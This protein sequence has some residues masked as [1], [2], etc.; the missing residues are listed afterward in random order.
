M[1]ISLYLL[2]KIVEYKVPKEV[3]GS[4][5]FPADEEDVNIINFEARNGMWVLYKTTDVSIMYDNTFF[6]SIELK[7][8]N[9]YILIYEQKNYLIYVTSTEGTKVD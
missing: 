6:D 5:S 3:Q 1:I 8:N 7:P 9:F 4:Y 2:D